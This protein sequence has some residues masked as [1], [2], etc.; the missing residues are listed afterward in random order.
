VYVFLKDALIRKYGEEFYE[1]LAATAAE[2]K[3]NNNE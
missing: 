1:T 3:K 2:M